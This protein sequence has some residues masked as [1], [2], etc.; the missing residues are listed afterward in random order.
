MVKNADSVFVTNSLLERVSA[1]LVAFDNS[2]DIAIFKLDE[3]DA[4][5]MKQYPFSFNNH[6]SEIGDKVFTIGYPRKDIV[7]GEGALSSL[8]GYNNDTTMFQISIPVNPG[9][10]GGPLIDEKGNVIGMIRGKLSNA[11]GTGFAIK[12][13]LLKQ[14]IDSMKVETIKAELVLNT[15]KSALKGLKRSEQIKRMEPFVFNIMVYKK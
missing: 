9:N 14:I 8:S 6:Q 7:Y 15:K 4:I 2:L 13:D 1:Q 10:S 12:S 3:V 5:S 11:E